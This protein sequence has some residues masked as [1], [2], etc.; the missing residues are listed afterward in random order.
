VAAK[1]LDGCVALFRA[2]SADVLSESF[3]RIGPTKE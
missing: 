1:A 3:H 2:L